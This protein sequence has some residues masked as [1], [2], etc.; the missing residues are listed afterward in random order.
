MSF[1]ALI[2]PH[3]NAL[4]V[5]LSLYNVRYLGADTITVAINVTNILIVHEKPVDI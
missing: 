5:Q 2:K 3:P 1:Q 4:S